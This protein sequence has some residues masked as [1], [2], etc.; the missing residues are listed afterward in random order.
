MG[1]KYTDQSDQVL[2]V[3][4]LSFLMITLALRVSKIFYKPTVGRYCYEAQRPW[5]ENYPHKR[6][7]RPKYRPTSEC[8]V[9]H[10]SDVL[11]VLRF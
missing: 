6:L 3:R 10:R 5:A 9:F 8:F 4:G 11:S 7:K 1:W 2:T